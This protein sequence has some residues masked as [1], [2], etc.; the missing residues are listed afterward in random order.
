MAC[1]LAGYFAKAHLPL[2]GSGWPPIGIRM[3]LPAG[4]L[5]LIVTVQK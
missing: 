1:Y 5:I 3:S 4:P 2:L